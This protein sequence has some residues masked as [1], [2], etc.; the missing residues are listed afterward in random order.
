[1]ASKASIAGIIVALTGLLATASFLYVVLASPN[2]ALA[3]L[4]TLPGKLFLGVLSSTIVGFCGLQVFLHFHTPPAKRVILSIVTGIFLF[5]VGSH[6]FPSE[7]GYVSTET[8]SNLRAAFNSSAN[9]IWY[10][11]MVVGLFLMACLYVFVE[12]AEK[13][14]LT[15]GRL[16][17]L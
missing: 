4:D 5:G 7:I 15:F 2:S 9:G 10:V 1:M 11:A 16:D 8:T 14:G 3:Y 12:I 17:N 6:Y 13:I